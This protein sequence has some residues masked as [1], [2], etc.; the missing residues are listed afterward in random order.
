MVKKKEGA[1][2]LGG[3]NIAESQPG[4]VSGAEETPPKVEA[5]VPEPTPEELRASLVEAQAEIERKEEVI[6]KLQKRKG[7]ALRTRQT[8]QFTPTPQSTGD[9]RVLE[10]LLEDKIRQQQETGVPDAMVPIIQ[11]EITAKRQ[12]E[13]QQNQMAQWQ[14]RVNQEEATFSQKIDEL[15]LD[16]DDEKLEDARDAFDMAAKFTGDFER[17]YRKLDKVVKQVEPKAEAKA[18][19]EETKK[20]K[21]I[22]EGKRQAL[23]EKG[24]LNIPSGMPSGGGKPVYKAEEIP[25]LLDPSK[26]TPAEITAKLAEIEEAA[27]EGRVK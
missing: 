4:A 21:W 18:E 16:P 1:E 26:M 24:V 17:A 6:K 2:Q 7:E 3:E 9:I 8:T 25:Q 15:G 20:Q 14:A 12:R 27:R 22:E 19:S 10:I 11:A 5:Q 23:E 13:F